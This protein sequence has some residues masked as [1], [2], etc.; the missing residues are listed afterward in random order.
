MKILMYDIETTPMKVYTWGLW[1][2]NIGINQIIEST[3]MMCYGARF[4]GQKKMN[5]K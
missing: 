5:F 2:Q 3:E 1:Q 4:L